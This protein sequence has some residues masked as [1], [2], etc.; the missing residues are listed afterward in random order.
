MAGRTALP[1]RSAY[2]TSRGS[3]MGQVHPAVIAA[4]FAVF[5][6]AVVEP[7]VAAGWARTDAD[8]I[9][10]ARRRGAVAQLRR[11]LGPEP[12]GLAEAGALA[13]R[14]IDPLAVQRRP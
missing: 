4:A 11:V 10:A 9:G 14:A 3:V 5:D 13:E 7:A 8:T 2:L 1:D 6:P 12:D